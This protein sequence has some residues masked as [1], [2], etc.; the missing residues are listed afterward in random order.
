M[1]QSRRKFYHVLASM[2]NNSVLQYELSTFELKSR[3]SNGKQYISFIKVWQ[4]LFWFLLFTSTDTKIE[5][6]LPK[7]DSIIIVSLLGIKYDVIEFCN[8][9]IRDHRNIALVQLILNEPSIK[10]ITSC[11]CL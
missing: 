11:L 3:V 2:G 5:H 7:Y 4:N 8:I 9:S 10:T 1:L 6:G